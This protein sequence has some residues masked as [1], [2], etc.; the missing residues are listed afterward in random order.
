MVMNRWRARAWAHLP[1]G[2]WGH[3]LLLLLLLLLLPLVANFLQ[4]QMQALATVKTT[5]LQVPAGC[6][7]LLSN[8]LLHQRGRCVLCLRTWSG[9]NLRPP[10]TAAAAAAAAAAALRSAGQYSNRR[11]H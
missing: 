3:T 7:A 8:S 11:H 2:P 9:W 10:S 4:P 6:C 1:V 5:R